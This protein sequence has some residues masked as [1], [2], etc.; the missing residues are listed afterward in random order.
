VSQDA[1]SHVVWS[2]LQLFESG[3]GHCGASLRSVCVGGGRSLPETHTA[4]RALPSVANAL[5]IVLSSAAP[6]YGDALL[7]V[8]SCAAPTYGDALLIVL[9]CAAPTYGDAAAAFS[10]KRHY[11]RPATGCRHWQPIM[12]QNLAVWRASGI[13][14][15]AYR[16]VIGVWQMK[17]VTPGCCN[18]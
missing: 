10:A 9:S 18:I 16:R 2:A 13:T 15:A 17:H 11:R 1:P 5:L 3:G 12:Y 8:L 14:L 4:S 7:I 6:T